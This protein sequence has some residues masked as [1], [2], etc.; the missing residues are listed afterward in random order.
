MG[1]GG[2]KQ[3]TKQAVQSTAKKYKLATL[4]TEVL[5]KWAKAYNVD[6]AVDTRDELLEQLVEFLDMI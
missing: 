4:E 1:K 3:S 5:R 2:E 6:P